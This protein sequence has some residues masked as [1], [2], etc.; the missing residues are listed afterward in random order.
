MC[1][2]CLFSVPGFFVFLFHCLMKENVRKQWR[3][4]LCCGRFRLYNCTGNHFQ[5][6]LR[7]RPL[8]HTLVSIGRFAAD[9]SVVAFLSPPP[10][11]EWS[12][13]V[14]PA[15]NHGKSNLVNSDSV[16]S[17]STIARKVSDSSIE[18]ANQL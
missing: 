13:R 8:C 16:A 6:E 17:D 18:S 2:I 14:M 10:P 4:H 9:N 3:I 15:A 11:Q 7:R 12:D 1:Q 5:T